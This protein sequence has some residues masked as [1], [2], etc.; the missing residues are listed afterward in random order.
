LPLAQGQTRQQMLDTLVPVIFDPTVMSKRV[1]QDGSQDLILSS[2]NNL[3]EGVT[4]AEV[5]AYYAEIKDLSDETPISYGLNAKVVK[6]D[7][8]V[9]RRTLSS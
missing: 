6:K 7:G 8:K 1:N 2:A 3:Y 5:E 9:N 4:Q